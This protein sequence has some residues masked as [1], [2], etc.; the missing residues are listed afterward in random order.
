[1]LT[2]HKYIAQ[3]TKIMPTIKGSKILI[4]SNFNKEKEKEQD[5]VKI[6]KFNYFKI[7]LLETIWKIKDCPNLYFLKNSEIYGKLFY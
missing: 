6:D 2:I 7:Q 1:M 5:I 4:I 3:E